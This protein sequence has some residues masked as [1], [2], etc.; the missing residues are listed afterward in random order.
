L[1]IEAAAHVA[2]HPHVRQPFER[3]QRRLLALPQLVL[4]EGRNGRAVKSN[5]R[6][7]AILPE[8][9]RG[10]TAWSYRLAQAGEKTA[11][12]A[13]RIARYNVGKTRAAGPQPRNDSP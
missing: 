12:H 2:V 11:L 5:E 13:G 4:E 1:G 3:T 9:N 8:G 6:L 7:E 10:Q